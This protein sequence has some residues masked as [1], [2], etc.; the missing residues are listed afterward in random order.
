MS[1]LAWILALGKLHANLCLP[2]PVWRVPEISSPYE[3][4]YAVSI[5]RRWVSWNLCW[6]PGQ[7]P[8]ASEATKKRHEREVQVCI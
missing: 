8:I 7:N 6:F 2:P 5:P 4:T 1:F 3:K